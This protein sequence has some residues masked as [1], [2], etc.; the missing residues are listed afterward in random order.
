VATALVGYGLSRFYLSAL[1]T[2]VAVTVVESPGGNLQGC[3]LFGLAGFALTAA[4]ECVRKTEPAPA[5]KGISKT[6]AVV[7][8]QQLEQTPAAVP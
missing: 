2:F 6:P 5:A 8:D 4:V 7:A 1:Q 3:L